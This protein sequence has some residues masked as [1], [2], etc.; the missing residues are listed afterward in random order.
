M[1]MDKENTTIDRIKMT[2]KEFEEFYEID[3][4]DQE[5]T[6]E[7]GASQSKSVETQS[8]LSDGIPNK[9]D[10]TP[11]KYNKYMFTTEEELEHDKQL[12]ETIGWNPEE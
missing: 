9:Q 8:G 5:I 6:E 11:D 1:K 7:T 2:Q 12:E 4:T 3:D 10:T